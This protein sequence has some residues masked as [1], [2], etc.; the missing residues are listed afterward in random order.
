MKFN[1]SMIGKRIREIDTG[2]EGV[3]TR[4][5]YTDKTVYVQWDGSGEYW[6]H[7]DEIEFIAKFVPVEITIDGIRYKL[8]KID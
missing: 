3:I 6:I 4:Q 2:D 5:G 7:L 1:E 8:T